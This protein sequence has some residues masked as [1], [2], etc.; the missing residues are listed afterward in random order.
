MLRR[1]LGLVLRRS[2]GGTAATKIA[3]GLAMDAF[4]M[5]SGKALSCGAKTNF[6]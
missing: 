2:T 1:Q 4:N 6:S 5:S 3:M